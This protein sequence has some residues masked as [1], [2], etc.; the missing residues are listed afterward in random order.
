MVKSEK[1]KWYCYIILILE[2]YIPALFFFDIMSRRLRGLLEPYESPLEFILSIGISV[3]FILVFMMMSL[4]LFRK[5]HDEK[6]LNALLII[7]LI[8]F[9]LDFILGTYMIFLTPKYG[10]SFLLSFIVPIMTVLPVVIFAIGIKSRHDQS[11][12]CCDD[13]AKELKL[14][15]IF[16]IACAM[17]IVLK[18][19]S[20]TFLYT[21]EYSTLE[22]LFY[23]LSSVGEVIL[24]Y[25]LV[26]MIFHCLRWFSKIGMAIKLSL[27]LLVV[28]PFVQ[29]LQLVML[30]ILMNSMASRNM[31]EF[32]SIAL[33]CAIIILLVK[34]NSKKMMMI[35]TI[36]ATLIKVGLLF[37]R[38]T[39]ILFAFDDGIL[40]IPFYLVILDKLKSININ[41]MNN[42]NGLRMV[43]NG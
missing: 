37:Y 3:A 33:C 19:L 11:K 8:L 16:I 41:E 25:A 28:M 20:R 17:T 42:D 2:G 6:K 30:R 32:V 23:I 14:M 35:L 39:P 24:K 7:G 1:L 22:D 34:E 10:L 31:I 21:S 18:I 9:S 15:F 29:R 12:I 36:V 5:N 4:V 13:T 27:I 43:I 38:H 40:M 26:V